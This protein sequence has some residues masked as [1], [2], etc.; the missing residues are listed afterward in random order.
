[1]KANFIKIKP[2]DETISRSVIIDLHNQMRHY[3]NPKDTL[4]IN[5][6]MLNFWLGEH[7][8]LS[9][10]FLRFE[11]NKNSIVAWAGIVKDPMLKDVWTVGYGVLP[12]YFKTEL[13]GKL[14]EAILNLGKKLKVPELLFNT[15]GTL[16]APFDERLKSMGFKPI[17]YTWS[18]RLDDF[19]LFKL[20]NTPHGII[21]RKQLKIND[22]NSYANVINLAFQESFKWEPKTETNFEQLMDSMQK[23]NNIEHCFAFENNKLVGACDIFTNQKQKDVG[24]LANFGILPEYQ[25]RGIGS[26]LFAFSVDSLREKGC[27]EINLGVETKNEKALNLYKTFGFYTLDNLTEK[28]YQII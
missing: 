24:A 16:S 23:T 1:M 7:T 26:T 2:W 10:D 11:N 6:D 27:K 5:E 15:T 25:H 21:I 28:R 4:E 8:I 12:E 14:I 3:L 19:N 20:P 9:R 17:H 18:M 13:P 22:Y